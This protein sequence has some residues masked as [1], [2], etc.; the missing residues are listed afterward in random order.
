MHGRAKR[1]LSTQAEPSGHHVSRPSATKLDTNCPSLPS[2]PQRDTEPSTHS[3]R[4]TAEPRSGLSPPALLGGE[5]ACKSSLS[6]LIFALFG[7]CCLPFAH[8][9][10]QDGCNSSS[11]GFA[12]VSGTALSGARAGTAAPLT[13]LS[14]FAGP[15]TCCRGALPFSA[16]SPGKGGG[17]R[18]KEKEKR[19]LLEG[20]KHRSHSTTF[21]FFKP[22]PY[23]LEGLFFLPPPF[24]FL[25]FQI[26]NFCPLHQDKLRFTDSGHRQPIV[27]QLIFP[28]EIPWECL[29]VL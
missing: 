23:M 7:K 20:R 21:F 10:Q 4:S 9:S 26:S 6:E 18:R 19:G 15:S 28:L 3:W 22:S 29:T 2:P 5:A 25:R 12:G 16:Q 11:P 8:P 1:F 13:I 27:V 14:Q 17:K 24:F